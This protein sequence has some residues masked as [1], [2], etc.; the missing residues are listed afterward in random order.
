MMMPLLDQLALE[1]AGTVKIGK[2]NIAD[3]ASLC[4]QFNVVAVPTL[5]FFKDG[6]PVDRVTG[7][8]SKDGIMKRLAAV[9]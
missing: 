5:L 9:V 4:V 8:L 1:K 2:V 3:C 6:K 7:T